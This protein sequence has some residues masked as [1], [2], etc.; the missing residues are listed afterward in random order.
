MSSDSDINHLSWLWDGHYQ[1]SPSSDCTEEVDGGGLVK[2][3][4]SLQFSNDQCPPSNGNSPVTSDAPC[5]I[6]YDLAYQ[7]PSL[8]HETPAFQSS[9]LGFSVTKQF[10]RLEIH[11]T[12]Y[13]HDSFYAPLSACTEFTYTSPEYSPDNQC[14]NSPQS[15][16]RS[17]CNYFINGLPGLNDIG[18]GNDDGRQLLAYPGIHQAT[19]QSSPSGLYTISPEILQPKAEADLQQSHYCDESSSEYALMGP[20]NAQKARVASPRVL[21]ASRKRRRPSKG[22]KSESVCH[23]CLATFT[24]RHNLTNHLNSHYG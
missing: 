10:P 16:T 11:T 4:Y 14:F 1:L 8:G 20:Q 18:P 9:V 12:R 2:Y 5:G 23:L 7:Q 21:A 3:D 15:S 6:I 13:P 19:E 17:D 24:A 22:A